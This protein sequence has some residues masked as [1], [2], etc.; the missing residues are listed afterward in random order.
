MH[1]ILTLTMQNQPN[2]AFNKFKM[3]KN[4]KNYWSISRQI[5]VNPLFL[6]TNK[7]LLMSTCLNFDEENML[8]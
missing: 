6:I 1:S 2:G 5:T 4:V 3:L 7:L 8:R